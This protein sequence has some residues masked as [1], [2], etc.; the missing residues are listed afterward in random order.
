[1]LSQSHT[2]GWVY[3]RVNDPPLKPDELPATATDAT[4]TNSVATKPKRRK[5]RVRKDKRAVDDS[6]PTSTVEPNDTNDDDDNDEVAADND[7]NNDDDDDDVDDKVPTSEQAKKEQQTEVRNSDDDHGA[8]KLASKAN[9]LL[10][11][12]APASTLE[13]TRSARH[14]VAAAAAADTKP[15]TMKKGLSSSDKVPLRSLDHNNE[16]GDRK[17]DTT[18]DDPIARHVLATAKRRWCRIISGTLLFFDNEKTTQV[19]LNNSNFFIATKFYMR[20]LCRVCSFSSWTRHFR[21]QCPRST[22]NSKRRMAVRNAICF[23]TT[24]V[25][26]VQRFFAIARFR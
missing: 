4:T 5:R 23:T 2:Y 14:A 9:K 21:S 25:L 17:D 20:R 26:R 1:M 7:N 10:G 18:S 19:R 16:S 22:R 12:A 8:A 15:A 13:K 6:V 3:F 11:L 24:I